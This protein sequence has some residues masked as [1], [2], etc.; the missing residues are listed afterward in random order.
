LR[1]ENG[2]FEVGGGVAGG[3]CCGVVAGVAGLLCFWPLKTELAPPDRDAMIESDSEVSMKIITAAVVARESAEAAPRGPNV[4]WL[5]VPPNA[6]AKSALLPLC[7]STTMIR[8]I[9]TIT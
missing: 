9:Q 5:P 8:K 2:Y 3:V 7:S 1:K 6:P 4:L